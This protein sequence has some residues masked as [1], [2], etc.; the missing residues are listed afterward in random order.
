MHLFRY[1]WRFRLLQRKFHL[2]CHQIVN[3]DPV[4]HIINYEGGGF[5]IISGDNRIEPMLAYA[6]EGVFNENPK[7]YPEGLLSWINHIKST[8]GYI[9]NNNVETPE[10]LLNHWKVSESVG[11]SRAIPE[12][13]FDCEEGEI[14]DDYRVNP[15]LSTTWHQSDPFNWNMDI[16]ECN[17]TLK[18]Q[19]VG[20]LP[21]AISQILK[22]W[23]Y[24]T[25]YNWNNMPN[26][27]ATSETR[28]LIS[29]VQRFYA[30]YTEITSDC[31]GTA[32]AEFY[33]DEVL[34]EDFGYQSAIMANYDRNCVK[35]ELL[36]E[37]RP[38]LFTGD[39]SDSA[40]VWIADGIHDWCVCVVDMNGNIGA[41]NYLH[42]HMNW[43]WGG[44]YDGWYSCGNFNI[45][46]ENT[47]YDRNLRIVYNIEP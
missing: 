8:I 2:S 21:L 22:Y 4:M 19:S 33:M 5:S 47:T 18:Y 30:Q 16:I 24:P 43:G 44:L 14:M 9:R 36:Y 23:E 38:V 46:A 29:D 41:N 1:L 20:C 42:F 13:S 3:T 6:D 10:E 39:S 25:N 40:H 37:R 28:R 31:D 35:R 11:K 17:G 45:P 12:T 7:N 32:A 27:T 15:M 34:K 26:T